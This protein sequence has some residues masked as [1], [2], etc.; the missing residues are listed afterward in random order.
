MM[1]A[2]FAGAVLAALCISEANAQRVVQRGDWQPEKLE[3]YLPRLNATIPWVE[4]GTRDRMPQRDLPSGRDFA[5]AGPFVM[6]PGTARLQ[7]SN[8]VAPVLGSM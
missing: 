8:R 5:S 1:K 4:R 7:A 6:P 3:K 2:L